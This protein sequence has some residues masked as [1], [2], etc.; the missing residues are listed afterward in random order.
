MT[1]S[2]AGPAKNTY[3]LNLGQT[4]LKNMAKCR[5]LLW[6]V[7]LIATPFRLTIGNSLTVGN[8][9]TTSGNGPTFGND[10]TFGNPPIFGNDLT[11]GSDLIIR[12]AARNS[13]FLL[14][15]QYSDSSGD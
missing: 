6:R 7:K 2:Q 1:P 14:D 10:L 9:P 12:N 13:K 3:F 11:F 8:D 5:P 4:G 15:M